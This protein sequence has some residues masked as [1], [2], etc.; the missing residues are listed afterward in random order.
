MTKTRYT[1]TGP[2]GQVYTRHSGRTYTHVV[3]VTDRLR[4]DRWAEWAGSRELA[5]KN[6][7]HWNA[8]IDRRGAGRETILGRPQPNAGGRGYTAIVVPVAA[9]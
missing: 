9:I 4:G 5:E 7:R 8:V 1:A 6:A 3:I 2:D